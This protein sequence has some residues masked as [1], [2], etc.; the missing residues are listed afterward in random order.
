MLVRFLEYGKVAR[1]Y[2]LPHPLL[3]DI[4]AND[5]VAATQA[6]LLKQMSIKDAFTKLD[7]DL[8]KKFKEM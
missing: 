6:A 8:S 5:I 3:A 2:P 4:A 7:A 1:A